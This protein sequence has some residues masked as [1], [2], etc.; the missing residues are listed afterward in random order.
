MVRKWLENDFW[1]IKI[2][3]TLFYVIEQFEVLWSFIATAHVYTAFLWIF[4]PTIEKLA[5]FQETL[6]QFLA[7]TL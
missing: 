6:S 3:D 2:L 7:D 5:I 4:S 1:K